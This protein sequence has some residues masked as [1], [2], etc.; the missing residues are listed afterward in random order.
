MPS[1]ASARFHSESLR[2]KVPIVRL[3]CGILLIATFC[4]F[5]PS[6]S[7]AEKPREVH[8]WAF[9]FPPAVFMGKNGAVQGWL[10]DLLNEVGRQENLRFVFEYGAWDE[11]L[12]RAQRDQIDLL[13][14]V[15]RTDE[16]SEYL[17]YGTTPILTVWGQIFSQEDSTI[18][19][20]EEIEGQTV[21]IMRRDYNAQTFAEK[22]K[23]PVSYMLTDSFDEVF[24]ALQART[25]DLGIVNSVVAENRA[26]HYRVRHT[27]INVSPFDIFFA[28]PKGRN[29]PLLATLDRY[30]E[31]WRKQENSFYYQTQHK[32]RSQDAPTTLTRAIPTW[33]WNA[34]AIVLAVTLFAIVWI[35]V[36]RRQVRTATAD[37]RLREQRLQMIVDIVQ[38]KTENTTEL[39]DKTLVQA[40][41]LTASQFGYIY[42]YSEESRL[43]TLQSWSE[44]VMPACH[45]PEPQT[46]YPLDKTGI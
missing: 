21:A 2:R 41:E 8:V 3:L 1:V 10:V 4:L 30:L 35:V 45:V 33:L 20:I 5:L 28:S 11:G 17:D 9:E 14:S 36:L 23:L 26:R 40:L 12:E 15:A 19:R 34:L 7:R 27:G 46:T 25:A 37:L 39:I 22:F 38:S 6:L 43:F 18:T 24:M 16:R 29:L 13:T 42:F 31:A 32:W 44:E